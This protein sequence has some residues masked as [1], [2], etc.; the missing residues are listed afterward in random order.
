MI[1]DLVNKCFSLKCEAFP[2]PNQF[3]WTQ[4]AKYVNYHWGHYVTAK[5]PVEFFAS[6][7]AVWL[8]PRI[9][10][11]SP[12]GVIRSL[13]I[14]ARSSVTALKLIPLY[15]V[16][17]QW[18]HALTDARHVPLPP[19]SLPYEFSSNFFILL[20]QVADCRWLTDAGYCP[21]AWTC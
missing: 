14:A 7:V 16:S 4:S 20:T 18:T 11:L 12:R 19:R 10:A 3:E 13:L 9:C 15:G 6:P 1:F 21:M 8:S 17:L 5:Q 2:R